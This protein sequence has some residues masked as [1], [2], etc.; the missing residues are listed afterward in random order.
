MYIYQDKDHWE[1]Q[2]LQDIPDW[3]PIRSNWQ[4]SSRVDAA[5]KQIQKFSIE[6]FNKVNQIEEIVRRSRIVDQ[7]DSDGLKGE[8]FA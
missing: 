5:A 8:R 2:V 7:S 6:N 3:I 1:T 4:L